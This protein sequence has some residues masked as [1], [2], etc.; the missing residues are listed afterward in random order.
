MHKIKIFWCNKC[1]NRS[2][3]VFWVETSGFIMGNK[4]FK[5]SDMFF[6]DVSYPAC[7]QLNFE[8]LVLQNHKP[9]LQWWI[10][11]I[12][13]NT[14]ESGYKRQSDLNSMTHKKYIVSTRVN[15]TVVVKL[16]FT[17]YEFHFNVRK[18][19]HHTTKK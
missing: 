12:P 8:R 1:L 11:C 16:W 14:W 5:L 10:K 18:V 3:N 2:L 15:L 6:F 19:K 4:I 7:K 13:G 9:K 17:M